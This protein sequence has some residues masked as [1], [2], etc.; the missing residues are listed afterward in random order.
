[1]RV[2]LLRRFLDRAREVDVAE[3]GAHDPAGGRI[4]VHRGQQRAFP[5]QALGNG[6]PGRD[7]EDR[8][9][10]LGRRGERVLPVLVDDRVGERPQR[11]EQRPLETGLGS[12]EI[13]QARRPPALD[14]PSGS[15]NPPSPRC[16]AGA[17]PR[18]RGATPG[19]ARRPRAPPPSRSRAGVRLR[20]AC[21]APRAAT[22]GRRGPR[23]PPRSLPL[24][25]G[26]PRRAPGP[27][28]APP[29]ADRLRARPRRSPAPA[30]RSRRG[31][32]RPP[33]PL[34]GGARRSR[35]GADRRPGRPSPRLRARAPVRRAP[36]P[37]V[38]GPSRRARAPRR[39]RRAGPRCPPG[40]RAPA[41]PCSLVRARSGTSAP[42][43]PGPPVR[44]G[45][46]AR[47]RR[48]GGPR[49]PGHRR[50]QAPRR[51][52][53]RAGRGPPV[54]ASVPSSQPLLLRSRSASSP[55][56]RAAASFRE[57]S[58][59]CAVNVSCFFAISA[60][61]RSGFSC[62]RSSVITSCRRRRSWSRAA[63]LRSARSLRRRCF[64]MPAASSMYFRRSSGLESSTSSSWP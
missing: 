1:M 55:R 27:R 28:R 48:A 23:Y 29:R 59:A 47:R 40:T 39:S 64:A 4:G 8:S 44:L 41:A 17:P 49:R 5:R 21:G 43:L 32:R 63:S 7:R 42:P 11:C 24:R 31:A 16:R 6:P 53:H 61:C 14:G 26:A 60:C 22:S 46:G 62:R 57:S 50:R 58:S 9:V 56:N 35:V 45:T 37:S 13:L 20:A 34:A 38:R 54:V 36:R 51:P 3:H 33:R 10:A 52:T 30:P 15:G 12:H 25:S 18:A 19:G 2:L